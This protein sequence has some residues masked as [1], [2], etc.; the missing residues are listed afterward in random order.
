M[1]NFSNIAKSAKDFACGLYK[2]TPASFSGDPFNTFL[3]LLWDDFCD[4]PAAPGLPPPPTSAFSG[5]QCKQVLYTVDVE[6]KDTGGGTPSVSTLNNK[7][8]PI[9]GLRIRREGITTCELVS[10]NFAGTAPVYSFVHNYGAGAPFEYRILNVVRQDGQPDICGNTPP[11][12]PPPS[13]PP[14]PDGYTSPP[15]PLPPKGLEPIINIEFNFTPPAPPLPAPNNFLPPIVINFK[16]VG[17]EFNI[18]ITFNFGGDVNFG[19]APVGGG[20]GLNINFNQDDRDNINNI[21]NVS[22]NTNN[23]TN[24]TNN[25][26]DN[27]YTDYRKERDK[28]DNKPPLP[29]DFDTPIPPVLPGKYQQSRLAF[30]NV[31]LTVSPKNAKSQ[32]GGGAPDIIYAGW[33]EF[34]RAGKALPRDYIHF[35][36]NCFVAPV[37]ADGY[38]FTLYNG[39]EGNAVAII[40]KE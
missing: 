28:T 24:N 12:F 14:P 2:Q 9:Q 4:Y 18:P 3:F 13:S 40:N 21:N 36:N 38:A 20:G 35:V 27:F 16:N 37:G 32:S 23:T 30:V 34:T 33:F 19:N 1:S 10:S 6:V 5:G 22:N 17:S 11:K 7:Y 29:T 8:G 31:D 15:I 26:V 39:Y 25:N